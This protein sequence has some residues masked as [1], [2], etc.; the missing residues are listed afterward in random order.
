[1]SNKTSLTTSTYRTTQLT[2]VDLS[3]IMTLTLHQ[4]SMDRM[5]VPRAEKTL[6][7]SALTAHFQTDESVL[8]RKRRRHE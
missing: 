1:M 3:R 2:T 6:A 5:T 4:A 8:L 7:H